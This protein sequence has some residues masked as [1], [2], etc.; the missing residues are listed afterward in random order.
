[1]HP[2]QQCCGLTNKFSSQMLHKYP[3]AELFL[4]S[5]GSSIGGSLW[6]CFLVQPL[7]E[8]MYGCFTFIS[9]N[10][11]WIKIRTWWKIRFYC[12]EEKNA[13]SG[14]TVVDR[15]W[16]DLRAEWKIF[17]LLGYHSGPDEDVLFWA[18]TQ[19]F[20][21]ALC[22]AYCL[23]VL[24]TPIIYI[25]R[26]KNQGCSGFEYHYNRKPFITISAR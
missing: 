9:F 3:D 12:S 14:Y 7:W 4:T 23:P 17:L 5:A 11:H 1:M 8:Q 26:I 2:T 18:V 22:L 6:L 13:R 15:Y 16:A 20:R 25:Y 24:N 21:I 10:I 19:I